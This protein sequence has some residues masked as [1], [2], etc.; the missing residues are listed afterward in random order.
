MT[1]IIIQPE[2]ISRMKL[3]CEY[4][5]LS[6][7]PATTCETRR[8]FA[9][10]YF[11][12]VTFHRS[13]L[14]VTQYLPQNSIKKSLNS[15]NRT[16]QALMYIFSKNMF[17]LG[18]QLLWPVPVTCGMWPVKETCLQFAHSSGSEWE[19]SQARM[20]PALKILA[21][22]L[23]QNFPANRGSFPCVLFSRQLTRGKEPLLAGKSK[24]PNK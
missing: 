10:R 9:G 21:K 23:V 15:A 24:M 22:P 7:A 12:Q 13:Q 4:S 19:N 14:Q 20:K 18:A 6:F 8:Q 3:A 2:D 11:L 5:R 17:R 1:L 16:R